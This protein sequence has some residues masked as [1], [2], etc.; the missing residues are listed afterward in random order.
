[1]GKRLGCTVFR[2]LP[3]PN[4]SYLELES[5]SKELLAPWSDSSALIPKSKHRPQIL[6]CAFWLDGL[7][8]VPSWWFLSISMFSAARIIQLIQG[9][10]IDACSIYL[11]ITCISYF[12]KGGS[13]KEVSVVY[14]HICRALCEG[15]CERPSFHWFLLLTQALLTDFF[16]EGSVHTSAFHSFPSRKRDETGLT[17]MQTR[18]HVPFGFLS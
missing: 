4:I 7:N 13:H 16:P 1:M 9:I 11:F 18:P 2:A 12:L 14:N 6:S 8:N 5:A 10:N 3:A 17:L 15:S